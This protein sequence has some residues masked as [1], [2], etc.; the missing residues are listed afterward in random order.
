MSEVETTLSLITSTLLL[1]IVISGKWPAQ[2]TGAVF[3][4]LQFKP[5][6]SGSRVTKCS[7]LPTTPPTSPFNPSHTH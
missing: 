2:V 7:Y 4:L 3:A 6:E 5:L 1:N